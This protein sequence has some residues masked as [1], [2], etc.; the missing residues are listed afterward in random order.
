ME[1]SE[2]T[3]LELDTDSVRGR[4][5]T[6]SSLTDINQIFVFSDEFQNRK[7]E[8]D[9]AYQ[10]EQE[11]LNAKVFDQQ[12]SY[13]DKNDIAGNLFLSNTEELIVRNE[14]EASYSKSVYQVLVL[15]GILLVFIL[16]TVYLFGRKG[17]KRHDVDNQF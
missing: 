10:A 1:T 11:T 12:I 16:G 7:E 13:D 4:T 8:V 5:E 3:K 6:R 17:K 14:Q 9:Q 15:P 2:D